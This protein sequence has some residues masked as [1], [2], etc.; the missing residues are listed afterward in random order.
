MGAKG[1]A[2]SAPG[3]QQG[4]AGAPPHSALTRSSSP[5]A[6]LSLSSYRPQKQGNKKLE[7]GIKAKNRFLL[8]EA[9]DLYAK[10]LELGSSEAAVNLA[11]LNNRAHVHS[12]LG[13]RWG[14]GG[15]RGGGGG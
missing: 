15:R 10:G 2:R 4:A 13:G 6:T 12:L 9:V 11:L 7:I 3:G 8:R 14:G 5:S 1:A